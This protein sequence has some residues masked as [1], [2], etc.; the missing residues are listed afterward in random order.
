V[1]C[2]A[3]TAVSSTPLLVAREV[4]DRPRSLASHPSYAMYASVVV[5]SSPSPV[6]AFELY[7]SSLGESFKSKPP[8]LAA[9]EVCLKGAASRC[10][11]WSARLAA[12]C[13]GGTFKR[14]I[15]RRCLHRR[16]PSNRGGIL[17]ALGHVPLSSS[18]CRSLMWHIMVGI[19][20]RMVQEKCFIG[21]SKCSN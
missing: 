6:V 1:P 8:D 18:Q 17:P 13:R 19:S 5:G 16:L 2:E 7:A 10:P 14:L 11:R 21:C 4:V 20:K 12:R 3:D 9:L 15:P